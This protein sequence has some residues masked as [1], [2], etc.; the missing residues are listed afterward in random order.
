MATSVDWQPIDTAPLA[1]WVLV[2][3]PGSIVR[4]AARCQ[5]EGKEWWTD[6]SAITVKLTHWAPLPSPPIDREGRRGRRSAEKNRFSQ[7]IP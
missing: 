5:V 7:I 6:G 3:G 2:W 4:S 1:E